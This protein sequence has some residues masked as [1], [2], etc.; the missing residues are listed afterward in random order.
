MER[1]SNHRFYFIKVYINHAVIICNFARIKFFVFFWSAVNVIEFFYLRI[2]S[3][4]R[5]KTCCFRSHNIYADSVI[6]GKI[7]HTRTYKF[8]NFIFYITFFKNSTD[9]RQC[10]ILRSYA[11]CRLSCKV[12]S[13]H[14]RHVNIVSFRKKLFYD[15]RTAFTASHSSQRTVTSMTVGT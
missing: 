1:H 7:S 11:F 13:N 12:N 14:A 8:H 5:R 9:Y 4:N 15:F 10:N 3:P 2:C 6:Y